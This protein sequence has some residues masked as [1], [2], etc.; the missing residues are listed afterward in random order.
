MGT[1]IA[2][3]FASLAAQGGII[4]IISAKLATIGPAISAGFAS[5][6]AFM[7]GAILAAHMAAALASNRIV[8]AGY[9]AGA[10]IIRGAHFAGILLGK[11]VIIGGI[12][13]GFLTGTA[14]V[15]IAIVAALAGLAYLFSEEILTA[16]STF[17]DYMVEAG[18]DLADAFM[19]G[20]K[21]VG[22]WIADQV[23]AGLGFLGDLLPSYDS[24]GT[25]DEFSGTG[26]ATGG[27]VTGAGTGTSDSIPAYLI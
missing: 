21:G 27:H 9:L 19:D 18:N 4:A 25:H 26:Y 7:R 1:K 2:V 22:T 6:M 15:V 24:S 10:A 23:K 17:G 8:Q 16:F 5:A 13:A 12:I 20:I 3:V 11:A 14:G